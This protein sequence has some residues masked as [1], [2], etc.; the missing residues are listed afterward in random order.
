MS[1]CEAAAAAVTA[2][3]DVYPPLSEE[4]PTA[5]VQA[6]DEEVA[7]DEEP[8]EEQQADGSALQGS[9]E[10]VSE[11]L[12]QDA[13]ET[14]GAAGNQAAPKTEN[15]ES[16]EWELSDVPDEWKPAPLFKV[17]NIPSADNINEDS[18]REVLEAAGLQVRSVAFD[19][20]KILDR[21]VAYVRLQPPPLPWKIQDKQETDVSKIAIAVVKRLKEADP[22]L[23]LGED[24]LQFDTSHPQ[25]QLFIGNI[26]EEW[27]DDVSLRRKM[28][29]YGP[30]ERCLVVHNH[31]GQTKGYAFVEYS[32]PNGALKC[33]EGM[34]KIEA[35]MR[36]D[37]RRKEGL[38]IQANGRWQ[39]IK[40]LRA[41]WAHPRTIPGLY[42]RVLYIT[43]L[44]PG[45]SDIS[46]LRQLFEKFGPVNECHLPRN[47]Q[48][49]NSKGFA[50]VEFRQ[51]IF[52]DAAYRDVDESEQD[53]MGS[54][55]VVSFANP[56]KHYDNHAI[57]P[58]SNGLGTALVGANGK[59]GVRANSG[60]ASGLLTGRTGL[61]NK[62]GF[63]NRLSPIGSFP[64]TRGNFSAA[65]QLGAGAM[66][67]N[68]DDMAVRL[69]QQNMQMQ[70]QIQLQ[71]QR[72]MQMTM[73]QQLRAQQALMQAQL[74]AAQ[75]QVQQYQEQALQYKTQ[76][77]Q[78]QL[79][80]QQ[81]TEA[82]KRIEAEAARAVAARMTEKPRSEYGLEASYS[83]GQA[84]F[85]SAYGGPAGYPSSAAG[86]S[87]QDAYGGTTLYSQ[88]FAAA[89]QGWPSMGSSAQGMPN[90]TPSP[91]M[92]G[93][94]PGGQQAGY[95]TG[96]QDL[97]GQSTNYAS[98][99]AYGAFAPQQPGYGGSQAAYG[100]VPQAFGAMPGTSTGYSPAAFAQAGMSPYAQA[101]N[102]LQSGQKRDSAYDQTNAYSSYSG[103]GGQ[104]G[105]SG[106]DNKRQRY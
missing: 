22:P 69:Q 53:F 86:T 105:Q 16:E 19:T 60:A 40:L 90:G 100:S 80:A 75:A 7:Y 29:E 95:G 14:T 104:G 48:T 9:A 79:K 61:G 13:A 4:A 66:G 6:E 102:N 49:G 1:D 41:E 15:L 36:P 33:K 101:T 91:A 83:G 65:G 10:V 25:V 11:V 73:Q 39:Q 88:G 64:N 81:E 37:F 32:V 89:S 98:P 24:K 34:D 57:R 47:K 55:L 70:Q 30:V 43:N 3:T 42:S 46:A 56:A 27:S 96:G 87:G 72:Q 59:L 68:N 82:R 76:A 92:Y 93:A 74:R 71:Y 106:Q 2:Q 99:G 78:A 35:E 94:S 28:E 54:K 23:Q 51:S 52:A 17:K 45:F 5:E 103:Y 63:S 38:T 31:K 50:F 97:F 84:A 26:T 85:A 62:A 67:F 12:Q 44:T 77:T 18:V 20:V 8:D 21:R 58:Q